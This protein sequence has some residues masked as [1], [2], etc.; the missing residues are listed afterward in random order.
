MKEINIHDL[1]QMKTGMK[2][3]EIMRSLV[4]HQNE[5]LGDEGD[6]IVYQD[7]P[8]HH[9]LSFGDQPEITNKYKNSFLPS[10]Y[11]KQNNGLVSPTQKVIGRYMKGHGSI[12]PE[13]NEEEINFNSNQT[14]DRPPESPAQINNESSVKDSIPMSMPSNSR[15]FGY[16]S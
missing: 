8:D 1:Y 6:R 7:G 5:Q 10:E 14:P 9:H 11:R 12:I 4:D 15:S 13:A 16:N 2:D 3:P